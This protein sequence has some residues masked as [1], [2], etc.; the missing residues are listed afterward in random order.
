MDHFE[1]GL[2][3]DIKSVIAGQTFANFQEM[4]QRAIK[5][6]RVLEE[7]EQET[8]ALHLEKRKRE[9]PKQGFQGGNVKRFRPNVPPRKGKQPITGPPKPYCRIYGKKHGGKCLY[10]SVQCYECGEKGHKKSKCLEATGNQNRAM[11]S[12]EQPRLCCTPR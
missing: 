7:I 6:T 10:G 3:G 11:P 2:R 8:Q 12:T 1:Q 4:Y 5:I 9:F